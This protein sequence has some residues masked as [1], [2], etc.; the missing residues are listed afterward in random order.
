VGFLGGYT[1]KTHRVF[2]GYVPGY[3]NPDM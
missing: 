2:F 3:L 1:R